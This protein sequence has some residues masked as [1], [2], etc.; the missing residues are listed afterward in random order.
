MA[1]FLSPSGESKDKTEGSRIVAEV[2][3]TYNV[4]R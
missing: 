4:I 3:E 1:I 2:E